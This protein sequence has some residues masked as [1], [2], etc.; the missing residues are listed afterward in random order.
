MYW[1]VL[2]A[3][4]A[5]P[6]MKHVVLAAEARCHAAAVAFLVGCLALACGGAD[7]APSDAREPQRPAAIVDDDIDEAEA[8]RLMALAGCGKTPYTVPNRMVH[9]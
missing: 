7:E 8:E 1:I 4:Y 6:T 3:G 9:A 5:A 2:R